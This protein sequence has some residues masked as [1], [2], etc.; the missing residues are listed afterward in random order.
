MK[1][2]TFSNGGDY[3]YGALVCHHIFDNDEYIIVKLY[4]HGCGAPIPYRP[5]SLYTNEVFS[6]IKIAD[7]ICEHCGYLTSC[8]KNLNDNF[9]MVVVRIDKNDFGLEEYRVVSDNV[10][11]QVLSSIS[12]EI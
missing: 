1:T 8:P 9:N 10:R 4:I 11:E 12:S 5:A 6:D 2:I 7:G 3:L